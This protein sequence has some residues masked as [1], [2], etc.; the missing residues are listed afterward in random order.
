MEVAD[1]MNHVT[2]NIAQSLYGLYEGNKQ[3]LHYNVTQGR[4][5]VGRA[6]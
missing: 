6:A 2:P 1:N 4:K 5:F 3:A